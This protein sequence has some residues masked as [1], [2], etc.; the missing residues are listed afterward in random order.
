MKNPAEFKKVQGATLFS[1]PQP[2]EK[3]PPLM[4]KGING[5]VKD[6]TYDVIAKAGGQPLILFLQDESGLGLRG[7]VGISRLLDQIAEKSE[8]EM[9]ISAVF[10]GDTPDTVENQASKLVSHIPNGVLLGVSQDGREGPG[11]YGLNRSVAQTVII[12]KDGKVLHNFAFTQPMLRPDP[13][14]LGA[15][16]D[17]IGIKPATLE[18]LLNE[19][20]LVIKINNPTVSDT[21]GKMLLNGT[22]VKF[23][24]MGSRLHDLPEEQKSM[25]TIQSGRDVPHE[26]IVKVMDI[27]KQAG[28]DKIGFAIDSA[29]GERM[30]R[31]LIR[32]LR[33]MV[34]KGEITGEEA[35]ERYEKAFPR[36][37]ED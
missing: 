3:L 13:Y 4:A 11:S 18:K 35:R 26:Q 28:I 14:L 19:K 22:V 36:S 12:A 10:L 21:M 5:N 23:D 16:G 15:V 27:A 6:K 25:L 34:E 1:G 2:G 33:E 8:Q 7:L 9:H 30:Q 37:K 31:A 17:A 20:G 32:L 24:D 29:E